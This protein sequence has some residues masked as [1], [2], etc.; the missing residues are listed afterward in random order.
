MSRYPIEIEEGK[1][2]VA[3]IPDDLF[4]TLAVVGAHG[5]KMEAEIQS[6]WE[7]ESA[8]NAAQIVL[9][10]EYQIANAD[11]N[12]V[13]AAVREDPR[14][15]DEVK[16]LPAPLLVH[17]NALETRPEMLQHEGQDATCDALLG[18]HRSNWLAATPEFE[19]EG[20]IAEEELQ[21]WERYVSAFR[22]THG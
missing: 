5:Q 12:A 7:A 11:D 22:A 20:R 2:A 14:L 4:E 16:S 8:C 9:L 18:A 6:I 19:K 1:H 17:L 15:P 13:M 3:S 21:H 10:G